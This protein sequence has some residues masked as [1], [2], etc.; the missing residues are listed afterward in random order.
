VLN[1][2]TSPKQISGYAAGRQPCAVVVRGLNV[3]DNVK[4]ATL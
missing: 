3:Q 4:T 1:F 2:Y